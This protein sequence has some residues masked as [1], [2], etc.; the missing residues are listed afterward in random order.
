[1]SKPE[2]FI[3]VSADV[4]HDLLVRGLAE[5]LLRLHPHI[6]TARSMSPIIVPGYPI[7]VVVVLH[8]EA[9]LFAENLCGLALAAASASGKHKVRHE[10]FTLEQKKPAGPSVN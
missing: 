2:D 10:E 8:P 3:S 7:S 1:M 4:A 9:E 6:G 5:A